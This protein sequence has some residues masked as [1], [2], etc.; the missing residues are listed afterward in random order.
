MWVLSTL[1]GLHMFNFTYNSFY[2]GSCARHW[3]AAL[4]PC[5]RINERLDYLAPPPPG[6]EQSASIV[7]YLNISARGLNQDHS[8]MSSHLPLRSPDTPKRQICYHTQVSIQIQNIYVFYFLISHIWSDHSNKSFFIGSNKIVDNFISKFLGC[9]KAR[10]ISNNYFI[11]LPEFLFKRISNNIS[12]KQY[13]W[14]LW[15]MFF[16]S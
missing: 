14:V 6:R 2:R 1:P 3:L 10:R 5:T 11:S 12:N 8:K 15:K 9:P 7:D 16:C 4:L 13:E